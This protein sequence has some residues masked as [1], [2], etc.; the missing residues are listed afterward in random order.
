[1]PSNPPTSR[2]SPGPPSLHASSPSHQWSNPTWGPNSV[3]PLRQQEYE[4]RTRAGTPTPFGLTLHFSPWGGQNASATMPWNGMDTLSGVSQQSLMKG[5]A[6]GYNGYNGPN[7]HSGHGGYTGHSGHDE[8]DVYHAYDGCDGFDGLGGFDDGSQL[9]PSA[10]EDVSEHPSIMN[11]R[12]FSQ[13]HGQSRDQARPR[14][15]APSR[16]AFSSYEF[17]R[18]P[19]LDN[20]FAEFS[21]KCSVGDR[22]YE[23]SSRWMDTPTRHVVGGQ[24]DAKDDVHPAP[25]E[26]SRRRLAF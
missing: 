19:S 2:R 10:W 23:T 4:A 25:V 12:M 16:N 6:N 20:I 3:H 8:Y 17:A 24:D 5:Y 26:R 13:I 22:H 14:N 15:P 7:G 9:I 21:E 11:S 18:D 1:M